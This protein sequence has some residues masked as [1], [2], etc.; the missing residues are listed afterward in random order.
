MRQVEF[1]THFLPYPANY[2]NF[3]ENSRVS[4]LVE[5]LLRLLLR[6]LDLQVTESLEQK[7]EQGIKAREAKARFGTRRKGGEREAE[8]DAAAIVLAMS[9]VRMRMLLKA[10]SN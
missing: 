2:T 8:E 1:E 5:G 7:L 4:I 3:V 10:S 6:Y 9:S